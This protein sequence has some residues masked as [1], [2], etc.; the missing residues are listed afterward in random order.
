MAADLV[1]GMVVDPASAPARTTYAGSQYSFCAAYCRAV[2]EKD[3]EK[4]IQD[5][6]QWGEAVD[7]VCGMSVQIPLAAAMS[8]HRGQF[9]YFCSE[10]C[11]KRFDASP[12]K[13]F[14]TGQDM[15]RPELNPGPGRVAAGLKKVEFP[16]SGMSCASCVARIE[17]GLSKMNGIADVKVNFASEKAFVTLDPTQVHLGDLI[18]TVKDLGYAAGMEKV[19][20]PVHGMS[21]ASCVKKVESALN[22]LEGVLKASVNFATER[23]TVQY[24]PG[25]VS[26]EDFKKAVKDA[27]YE[28]LE[29]GRVEKEDVVDREQAAREAEFQKLRVRFIS[30]LLLVIPVFLLAYWSALGLD[31]LYNLSRETGFFLQLLFQTPIQFWV[32]WRFYVGAWKS[33]KHKSA[34][35]N[36]LIAVGTSAAYLYSVAA[37]FFPHLF[38]A[39]GL[40]AAVYFDTAGAIIVLILLGRLLE[41]R[42]KGQ[43]SEAIKKLIGLQAKTARVVRDGREMDIPVEEVA[44]GDRVVVR[45]GEKI[46]VDGI[47]KEGHSAVDESMV[48]GESMPVEKQT[49]EKVIGATINKTGTFKFEATKIGKDTMLA[50]IIKMVEEAQGSKPPIARLADIIAAYFVPAVIGIAVITF[51]VW[52]IFGPAPALTYA[53]LNFVAVLII[54]CPCALGLATPTSIMVGTGKGAESGVL[55]R[56]GEALETAHKLNAV[57]LDKTG[58]LTEGKPSVTDIATFG[59]FKEQDILRFSASAEKGSEHPLGEAIVNRALEQNLPLA[60]TENFNAIAGHGIEATIEGKSVLLGNL[61]LM[62][63]RGIPLEELERKAEDFANQGKT[64]MFVAVDGK[65]AGI[66]AVA[67]TLKENSK[68][69]VEA[70][71]RMGIEVAMITGDNKRTAD[72]IAQ[73]IGID[74]V[75]AEVL[76]DGKADE[77]KKLQAEGKKVAMVGDGIN[78]APALAQADVGIAIGT[79]TDVAMEAA[80]ITLISGDL[81]GVLTAIALSRATIRNIKQNLFWAFAYNTILIPVA[82]GV[83]FPFFGI[84]LNPIFAAAAMGLSSVTVVSNALRLRR[85]RAPEL[86]S[87]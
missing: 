85:F 84:L 74:R 38:S 48:T 35:M 47:V 49:G 54:A 42:A 24:V 7:P 21:C 39:Q 77:V 64:P 18:A 33:A 61:K 6:K 58:T 20:L 65:P 2:F 30:G 28:I 40:A 11:K 86:A 14:N 55:I 83:L 25:A 70:L 63:D 10:A 72:A 51:G 3:P 66:V 34:D 80:D 81:Q 26:V 37:M 16:V 32:G 45:P 71:H 67:D 13:Y 52:Y 87:A 41:A 5:S 29:T 73:Q 78:D 19:T 31:R 53:V 59:G 75:L 68:A 50:Q 23:A 44:I 22:G 9:I 82:A 79:G 36:T 4:F 27:G 43:T 12:E 60:G 56:G 15:A 8:V 57:V 17:K 62:Q 76:P 46:P 69:A 1:C